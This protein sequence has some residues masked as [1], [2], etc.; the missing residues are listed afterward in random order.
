[1][2]QNSQIKRTVEAKR[3]AGVAALA[4]KIARD[5]NDVAYR[6]ASKYKKLFVAAKQAI[7]RK[8]G[9]RARQEWMK[10]QSASKESKHKK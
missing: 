2:V 10:L 3:A 5:K 9:G 7:L 8:Y 1:M 4:N 6:K